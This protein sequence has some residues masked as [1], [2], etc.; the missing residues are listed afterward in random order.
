MS[1]LNRFS[2]CL[3]AQVLRCW[4]SGSWVLRFT[5][6][7]MGSTGAERSRERP[8]HQSNLRTVSV[9]REDEEVARVLQFVPVHR[10]QVAAAG[11]HPVNWDK[12]QNSSYLFVFALN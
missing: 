11:L 2:G 6:G 3:G 5:G 4:C 1:R 8:E 12:L 10:M 9:Q 7:F